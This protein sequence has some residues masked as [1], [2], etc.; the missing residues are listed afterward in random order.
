MNNKRP[1]RGVLIPG[2]QMALLTS[3]FPPVLCCPPSVTQGVSGYDSVLFSYNLKFSVMRWECYASLGML[4]SAHVQNVEHMKYLLNVH[5][6]V[7]SLKSNQNVQL[8]HPADSSG[9]VISSSSWVFQAFFWRAILFKMTVAEIL[10]IGQEISKHSRCRIEKINREKLT[11]ECWTIP[12]SEWRFVS[13]VRKA[14]W[15]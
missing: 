15:L 6:F 13:S 12:E 3:A 8:N 1:K 11:C 10:G 7:P 4:M 5:D 9:R 14:I 2:W